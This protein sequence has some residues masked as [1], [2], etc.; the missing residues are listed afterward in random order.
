MSRFVSAVLHPFV[1]PVYT[2][3]VLISGD[4]LVAF[5]PL[6]T[7]LFTVALIVLNALIIP[8]IFIGLMRSS[9]AAHDHAVQKRQG[10]IEALAVVALC[11]G[12]S[13]FMVKDVLFAFIVNKFLITAFCCSAAALVATFFWRISLHMVAAGGATAIFAMLSLAGLSSFF[14]PLAV[15]ILLSGAL[16]SARLYLGV[17]NPAQV[18]LGYIVGFAAASL[19]MLFAPNVL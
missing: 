12:V 1:V 9:G 10:R 15:A 6:R 17:H 13:I 16:A 8:A 7:K 2:V 18:A 19:A 11:Y 5:S 3:A 4:F 14:M